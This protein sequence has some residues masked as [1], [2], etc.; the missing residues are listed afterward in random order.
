MLANRDK[1]DCLVDVL[2]VGGGMVGASL[3]SALSSAS[4]SVALVEAVEP[5]DDQHPSYDDRA[6]A[7]SLGSKR[8]LESLQVWRHLEGHV[9][10]IRRIHVSDRGRFGFARMVAAEHGVDAFGYVCDARSLGRAFAEDLSGR[11]HVQLECPA[12]AQTLAVEDAYVQVAVSS[13]DRCHPIRARLLVAADGGRSL[14]RRLVDIGAAERSYG[15][16]ALTANVTPTLD[17][18][19]TA[20]ERFTDSGPLALLPMRENRCGV[21]WTVKDE[22]AADLADMDD[23]SFLSE[24]GE[25]FGTRLGRFSRV[26]RRSR[27]RLS[28]IQAREQIRPRL[29]IIGNAAHTLHPIAAQGV[30]LGF[31]DVATLAQVV[32]DAVRAGQDPG[33]REVLARYASWRRDDHR[34]V[35]RFTDGLVWLFSNRLEPLAVGRNLGLLALDLM[36]GLKRGLAQQAMGL[37]GHQTRLARGLPL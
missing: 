10:P 16:T 14:I 18:R 23:A 5:E 27:H 22:D 33:A 21:V 19:G 17:H 9:S 24:L 1:T 32:V 12:E 36:P 3:A 8:I 29:A 37:A 13:A 35:T 31:R 15:Q 20:Y 30:N 28:L 4:L 11:Q 2:I 7:V 6:I 26:G 34:G 25:R